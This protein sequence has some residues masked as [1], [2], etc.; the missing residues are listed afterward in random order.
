MNNRPQ[1]IKG[2]GA[3]QRH[4]LAALSCG[5]AMSLEDLA[6]HIESR[7]IDS[8]RLA[9]KGLRDRGLPIEKKLNGAGRGA[10]HTYRLQPY[11][12]KPW[13]PVSMIPDFYRLS[14]TGEFTEAEA[15]AIIEDHMA[16]MERRKARAA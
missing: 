9:V 8:A 4:I 14:R 11:P 7:H 5:E 10:Y 2:G 16:V 6:Q 13:L 3:N 12:D 1:L 15:R